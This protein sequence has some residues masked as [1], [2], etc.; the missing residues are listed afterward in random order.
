MVIDR[1]VVLT[2]SMNFTSGAAQNS[3]NVALDGDLGGPEKFF[4]ERPQPPQIVGQIDHV[5]LERVRL[6]WWRVR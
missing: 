6:L 4:V 5:V 3:K 1:E 2:G